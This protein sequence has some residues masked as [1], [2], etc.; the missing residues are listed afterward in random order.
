MTGPGERFAAAAEALV[1]TPFRF[2]GRDR[3]TG[4]DCVG[5][6]LAALTDSGRPAPRLGGY[7]VRQS[8][9]GSRYSCL[10]GW[11]GFTPAHSPVAAGD[12]LLTQ[13]GPAQVHLLVVARDGSY[14]H[15]HAG[16]G[17]VVKTPPPCPW[18]VERR[19]RLAP[20]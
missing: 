15:A 14:I 3:Q 7:S 18:P 8:D 12:L 6:V 20:D 5:L 10:P 17:R 9:L 16:L 2:R 13:P 19:W 11:A 1:G 4:L